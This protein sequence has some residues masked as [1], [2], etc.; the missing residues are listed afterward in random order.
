MYNEVA[1]ILEV[2]RR[3]VAVSIPKEIIV[4]D[5]KSTDGT[6]NL[7]QEVKQSPASFQGAAIRTALPTVTG[8]A[9]IIQD[10]DLEYNPAEYPKLVEPFLNG[11]ADVV[12]GSRFYNPTAHKFS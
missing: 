1:T 7:L 4:V 2:F 6:V 9:I 8:D 12:Y 10:A 3:V 5:D 11:K